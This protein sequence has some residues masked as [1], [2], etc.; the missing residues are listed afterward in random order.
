MPAGQPSVPL[1]RRRISE[2]PLGSISGAELE[3]EEEI[4]GS[5]G[6]R[7]VAPRDASACLLGQSHH[8]LIVL[9]EEKP[10]GSRFGSAQLGSAQDSG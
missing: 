1:P 10:T 3:V 5:E 6:A 2:A 9:V 8:G 7:V 4:D